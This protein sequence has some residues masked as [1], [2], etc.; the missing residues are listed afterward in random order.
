[1]KKNYSDNNDKTQFFDKNIVFDPNLRFGEIISNN[2]IVEIFKCGNMGGMRRSH[3]TNSLVLIMD[4]IKGF[5]RD[6]RVREKIKY[7]GMGKTGYME[8][9]YAQNKTLHESNT[10]GVNVYMF[11]VNNPGEYSYLGR[12]VLDGEPYTEYQD[13]INDNRRRVWIFPL[14]LLEYR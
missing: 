6:K 10:N 14:R 1:M 9:N 11:E 4:H 8:L 2:K 12:V 7:T 13:D 5:Y 3:I